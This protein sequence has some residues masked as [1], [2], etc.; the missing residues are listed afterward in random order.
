MLAA[1]VC[2]FISK[3]QAPLLWASTYQAGEQLG[4]SDKAKKVRHIMAAVARI[5]GIARGCTPWFVMFSAQHPRIAPDSTGLLLHM[6]VCARAYV[7]GHVLTHMC[8]S[9]SV[10]A[11]SIPDAMCATSA[12]RAGHL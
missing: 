1:Y 8:A 6:F 3:E 2:S 12:E 11:Q 5:D 4:D 7:R 9:I 10:R